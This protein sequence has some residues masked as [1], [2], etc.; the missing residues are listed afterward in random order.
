MNKQSNRPQKILLDLAK[1]SELNGKGYA[2]KFSLGDTVVCACGGWN[3]GPRYILER[4]AVFDKRTQTYWQ[5]EY[6][7]RRSSHAIQ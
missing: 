2:G 7:H 5:K 4:D 3:D 6:Y 1:L